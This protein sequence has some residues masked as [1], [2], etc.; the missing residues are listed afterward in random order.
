MKTLRKI[1]C[2]GQLILAI[3]MVLSVP[4]FLLPL[5]LAGLF[6]MGFWQLISAISN[7]YAFIY[8]GYKKQILLYWKLC[9]ADFAL[10]FSFRQVDKIYNPEHAQVT[11]W[12]AI[13]GAVAIAVYYWKIYFKLI[14]HI[15][16]RNELQGLIKSKH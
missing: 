14:E 8:S 4:T 6:I 11:F 5:F 2:Y 3:L 13:A 10:L 12:I 1:D 7:T 9:I 15:A 16:L